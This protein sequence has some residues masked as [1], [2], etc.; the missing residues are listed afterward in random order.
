ML[1]DI[2]IIIISVII[3]GGG[4]YLAVSN[5]LE[6][7]AR[8]KKTTQKEVL[9]AVGLILA[10]IGFVGLIVGLLRQFKSKKQ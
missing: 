9:F 3:L 8:K 2:I 4:L 5:G 7:F 1:V 10:V 6:I